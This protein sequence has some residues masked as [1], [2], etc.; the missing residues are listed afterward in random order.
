[1]EEICLYII[2]SCQNCSFAI[3]FNQTIMFDKVMHIH[4]C[5]HARKILLGVLDDSGGA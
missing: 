3:K 4:M 5:V 2:V 1:M